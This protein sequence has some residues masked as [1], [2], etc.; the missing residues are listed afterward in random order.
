MTQKTNTKESGFEE[1]IENELVNNQGY[2]SR[3]NSSYDK[4]LCM[5]TELVLEFIQKTQNE[6]WPSSM[7][8]K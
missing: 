4:A 1:F 7:A 3:Q 2:L 6:S 8:M 5:D